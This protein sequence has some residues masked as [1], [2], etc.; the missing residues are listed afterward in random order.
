MCHL[1]A[2]GPCRLLL[3]GS[4][5]ASLGVCRSSVHAGGDRLGRA[6][7]YAPRRL[8][9]QI[10]LPAPVDWES[11]P[12]I[13]DIPPPGSV[14]A[15][16][17]PVCSVYA[18]ART[19]TKL[20]VGCSRSQPK[21][22]DR[23]DEVPALAALVPGGAGSRHCHRDSHGRAARRFRQFDCDEDL[24]RELCPGLTGVVLFLMSFTLD[25][26]KLAEALRSPRAVLWASL[27]N[28]GVLPLLAWPVSMW[29]LNP[30]YLL[31]VIITASVPS[32]MASASVWT[33]KAGGN[34]AV[35][36]LVTILTNGLCFVVTPLWLRTQIGATVSLDTQ[37]LIVDLLIFAMLPIALGQLS[38]LSPP[39][40]RIA[41]AFKT[42]LSNSAQV[43]ILIIIFGSA[44]RAGPKIAESSDGMGPLCVVVVSMASIHLVA[45]GIA[46]WGGK[47]IG[48]PA[49]MHWLLLSL[50]AKRRCR[51]EPIWPP[52][53]PSRE[54]AGSWSFRS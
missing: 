2:G 53:W 26:R 20:R 10:P 13:A 48:L 43:C 37:K 51:S 36:L 52:E 33:R 18:G 11:A 27:V 31:G 7:L 47:L 32:T 8:T 42:A 44:L 15:A 35:S 29:Q 14:I 41:D 6:I 39:I 12:R 4:C 25:S 19:R 5:G 34:D 17:Q 30:D 1:V 46:W 49:R 40:A 9:S 22:R 38:R 50:G 24:V 54:R 16:G 23:S 3:P 21:C 28:F 45:I